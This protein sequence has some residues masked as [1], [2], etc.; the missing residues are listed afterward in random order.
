L[1]ALFGWL[2]PLVPVSIARPAGSSEILPCDNI[3][4]NND[5]PHVRN[6]FDYKNEGAV[7]V[8]KHFCSPF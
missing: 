2:G 5:A 3:F 8:L 1:H 7:S 4:L 6:G